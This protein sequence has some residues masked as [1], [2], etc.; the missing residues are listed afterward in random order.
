MNPA[1]IAFVLQVAES[2]PSLIQ[3]GSDVVAYLRR[4]AAAIEAMQA[5]KRDPTQAEIDG[6][7]ATIAAD[8]D[9]LHQAAAIPLA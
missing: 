1:T 5:E 7:K 9:A 6:L 8:A 3:A 4:Q 2:L